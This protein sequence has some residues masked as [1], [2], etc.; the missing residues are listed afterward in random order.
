MANL[1]SYKMKLFLAGCVFIAY[2][3]HVLVANQKG[4]SFSVHGQSEKNSPILLQN[5]TTLIVP[6]NGKVS[7]KRRETVTLVCP[8]SKNYLVGTQSNITHAQCVQGHILRVANQDVNFRDLQCNKIIKGTVFKTTKK[9]GDNKGRIYKIGYQI[10]SRNFLTLIEVCYDPSSGSTLYT[11][12]LLHGQDIKYASKS[13]YR[14]AFSPE[15]SGVAVSVAYRQ[16][17]QKA[18]FNKLMK[19]ALKAQE[20]IN[21]NSFLSRGHLSPDADFLYAATQYTSYYYINAAPQ[22]QAINAGNWKKIELLIRK[23]AD[24]LQETLTIITGTYGVLTLPDINENEVDIYLVSGSKLPVPKFLWKIIYSKQ[25]RQAVVL[26]NLNNPFVKEIVTEHFLCP[27]ICSKVGWGAGSWSNYQRG[28]VYCC[29]YKQFVD[30]VE[31]APKLS[32]VGV[33]QGPK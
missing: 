14:P 17:F 13:N 29:D 10:S 27:N 2:L 8:D 12:H 3:V 21:D 7:L 5:D 9:C 16:T 4:C 1:Y 26:V 11:E 32:V 30:K 22:W 28:F 20:Y 15:A 31:T 19:S 23:L 6:N 18:T 24:N 33:L 25:L